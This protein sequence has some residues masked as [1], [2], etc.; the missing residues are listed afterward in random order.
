MVYEG[1]EIGENS[2]HWYLLPRL[3]LHHWCLQTT[4]N[5]ECFREKTST[6]LKLHFSHHA[7]FEGHLEVFSLLLAE[8]LQVQVKIETVVDV[9]GILIFDQD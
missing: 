6:I 8:D 9:A 5:M 3:V 2:N 1:I 7:H 4:Q